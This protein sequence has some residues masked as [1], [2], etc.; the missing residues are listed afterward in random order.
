[1]GAGPRFVAGTRSL[2]DRFGRYLWLRILETA[3]NQNQKMK[4]LFASTRRAAT[5]ALEG[6]NRLDR[7]SNEG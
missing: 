3:K 5:L 7:G 6:P 2:M 4:R 1:V